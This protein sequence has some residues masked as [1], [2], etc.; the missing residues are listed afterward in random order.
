MRDSRLDLYFQT[1]DVLP[2][3]GPKL[4]KTLER[5]IDGTK[6]LDLLLHLPHAW[7]DRSLKSSLSEAVPGETV[8]VEATVDAVVAPHSATAPHRIRLSDDTGFLTL[9]YFRASGPWLQGQ[10]KIG[11]RKIVSGRVDEYSGERQMAHPDYVFNA[12]GTERPPAVEPIYRLTAGLTNR[13][14]HTIIQTALDHCQIDMPEW[15]DPHLLSSKDWPSWSDALNG[16]HR[17]IDYN[18]EAFV[19]AHARLAYDEAL[20]RA[21]QQEKARQTHLKKKG[22]VIQADKEVTDD[23]LRRLPFKPTNAQLRA[24]DQI[25]ED[26]RQPSPMRR[27]LQGDVGSGKTLVSAMAALQAASAGYQT[28]I[29]APTEV[30]ALQQYETIRDLLEPLKTVVAPLTGRHK[31]S[32]RESTLM[33][34]AGGDIQVCVG[35]HALFQEGVIY[36]RLGLVIV[37]EQ[38]RF[39]V[40][41]RARLASKAEN[42]HLLAMSA[43]PIPRTLFMAVHGDLDVS[44]LDEKPAGRQPIET[45]ALPDTRIE[46]VIVAVARAT[47][48]GE[49]VFWVCPKVDVEEETSSA[50]FRHA[51]L[52][53]QLGVPVGLVHGRLKAQEKDDA[54]ESFR[55]GETKILVGTTV[56]EVGVDVPDATIMVIER[57]EMFGL[58]QLHQLRGRV[59]RGDRKSYCLLL[60]RPPLTDSAKQRLDTLRK[61]SDG[62]E[63][64]EADFK[65]RGPGDILGVNQSGA[66]SFKI[67]EPQSEASLLEIARKD[68]ENLFVTDPDL[69]TQRSQSLKLLDALLGPLQR[70]APAVS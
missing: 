39:G 64:A 20:A 5:L 61:T 70:S 25:V 19:R 30:L 49:R 21:V 31:G 52:S 51:A 36:H 32:L 66:L 6:I 50:V 14:L 60:Y 7:T 46:E 54:L 33:A 69:K 65:L 62:F 29:M 43:T 23:L 41:D 63:I 12:D 44:I 34:L 24:F 68:V 37:D 35:T 45:R 9:V 27:M 40:L 8:T 67:L 47:Q 28:A 38:H 48:N 26:M 4:S 1:L 17:P 16:L 18:E 2:G 53:E 22:P 3:V 55:L 42:P 10:F 13:R 15:I 59:G 11:Q 56:I 58:S 57:A